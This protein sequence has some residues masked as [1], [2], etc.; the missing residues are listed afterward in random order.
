MAYQTQPLI[1]SLK[2]YYGH[3][4]SGINSKVGNVKTERNLEEKREEEE[5]EEE[6]EDED[7]KDEE[8]YY[9]VSHMLYFFFSGFDEHK[10]FLNATFS[11]Q[12]L[13][14]NP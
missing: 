13:Y 5:E 1:Y 11:H 14:S 4:S 3:L 7:Y 10:I 6:E 9:E 12:E 8:Y 2:N